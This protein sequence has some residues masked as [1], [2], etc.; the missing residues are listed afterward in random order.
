MNEILDEL[1]RRNAALTRAFN[2]AWSG[3]ALLSL[4]MRSV[5]LPRH[6]PPERFVDREDPTPSPGSA[7]RLRVSCD[8]P[9]AL[10]QAFGRLAPYLERP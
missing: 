5:V 6:G 2:A 10:A 4:S 3:C 7:S 9:R 8:D 1:E